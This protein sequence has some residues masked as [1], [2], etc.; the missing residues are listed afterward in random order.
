VPCSAK[1]LGR[2]RCSSTAAGAQLPADMSVSF[3]LVLLSSLG[4]VVPP[5]E[6]WPVPR[7]SCPCVLQA[8]VH[9]KFLTIP[10]VQAHQKNA[11]SHVWGPCV[12]GQIAVLALVYD[13]VAHHG[14]PMHRTGIDTVGV[15]E[16]GTGAPGKTLPRVGGGFA[17]ILPYTRTPIF[18][19]L[20]EAKIRPCAALHKFGAPCIWGGWG[21]PRPGLDFVPGCVWLVHLTS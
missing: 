18:R 19:T 16:A 5:C 2:A 1:C 3:V 21:G 14:A 20:A 4:T 11:I 6:V 9:L 8:T 17:R 15:P 10:L 7:S 12:V 13:R